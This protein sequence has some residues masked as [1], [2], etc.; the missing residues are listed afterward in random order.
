LT[1]QDLFNNQADFMS[2]IHRLKTQNIVCI[3]LILWPAVSIHP[4]PTITAKKEGGKFTEN[5]RGCG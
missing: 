3:F 1:Q 5:I 4:L 2:K